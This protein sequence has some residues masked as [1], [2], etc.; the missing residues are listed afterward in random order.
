[1]IGHQ[2]AAAGI[3]GL[4]TTLQPPEGAEAQENGKEMDVVVTNPEAPV[5]EVTEEAEDN[6]KKEEEE[7]E[8]DDGPIDMSFPLKGGWKKILV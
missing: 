1:M 8:E 3:T 5:A 6:K 4:K 7:E 2:Q